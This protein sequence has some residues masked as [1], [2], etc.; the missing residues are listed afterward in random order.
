MTITSNSALVK[1]KE[2]TYI[3]TGNVKIQTKDTIV[4][5]DK[6]IAQQNQQRK[7]TSMLDYGTPAK[8]HTT[9][10]YNKPP[11]DAS[12][13][14]IKFFPQTHHAI[15]INEA[16]AK[17]GVNSIAA[18]ILH[19]NTQQK[20]IKTKKTKQGRTHIMIDNQGNVYSAK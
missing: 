10:D 7:F 16:F 17:Q 1:Y 6:V 2:K 13:Q 8:Y 20:V 15:L 12:A 11:L 9:L 4:Q 19:Y 3:F 14:I 5:G 18:P